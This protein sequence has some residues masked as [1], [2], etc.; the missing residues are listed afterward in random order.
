[1]GIAGWHIRFGA[2]ER[3]GGREAV[4]Y[5]SIAT[6]GKE[7]FKSA[8]EGNRYKTVQPYTIWVADVCLH[9]YQCNIQVQ[10]WAVNILPPFFRSS[11][12]PPRLRCVWPEMPPCWNCS[13][14]TCAMFWVSCGGDVPNGLAPEWTLKSRTNPWSIDPY[15]WSVLV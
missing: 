4:Y 14:S 7:S 5:L 6:K 9:V 11:S 10:Y 15:L 12:S 2:G 1:M 3:R 13:A 8:P